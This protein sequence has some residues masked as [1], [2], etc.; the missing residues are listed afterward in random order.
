LFFTCPTLLS[1]ADPVREVA[2]VGQVGCLGDAITLVI[3]GGDIRTTTRLVVDI[4]TSDGV[5]YA[6]QAVVV[7]GPATE[8]DPDGSPRSCSRIGTIQLMLSARQA[9]TQQGPA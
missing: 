6:H 9:P 5:V 3:S 7:L 8:F 2:G 4:Q 1:G